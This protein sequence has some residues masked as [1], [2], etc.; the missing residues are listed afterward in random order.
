ML[1]FLVMRIARAIPLLFILSIV[2]FAIIQAPP[3]DY[4]DY[5]RSHA[6]QPGRRFL[7][8]GR[9][10]A[11]GLPRAPTGSN[12]PLPVQYFN[13][14]TGIVTRGDFGH[15]LYYNKPVAEVVAERL[16][17]TIAA[18][19]GLPHPRVGHRHR[20]RHPRRDP[21]VFL[22]RHDAVGSSPSSA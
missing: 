6:D 21:A 22:G 19:A 20:L 16:P 5:I 3:G 17:R 1:R 4:G 7:R 10:Q 11:A 13:W 12:E 2:T 15:S 8:G 14:I 18:G 9:A